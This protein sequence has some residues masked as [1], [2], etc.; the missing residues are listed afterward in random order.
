MLSS[1]KSTFENEDTAKALSFLH[2]RSTLD[3]DDD[4]VVDVEN[5]DYCFSID[6]SFLDFYMV[7]GDRP[8]L[9]VLIPA[10]PSANFVFNLTLRM[11]IR[12]FHAKYGSLGFNP[13]GS[14]LF[15]GTIGSQNLWIAM[16]PLE[17]FDGI[18]ESFDMSDGHGDTRLTAHRYRILVSFWGTILA[19][20]PGRNF[21]M[22]PYE[23]QLDRG[24]PDFINYTNV[25]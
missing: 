18:G 1:L 6:N 23:A 22:F 24:T 3:I 11:P 8:G 20:L 13:S 5:P 14:M 9:D 4:F 25:M 7:I 19:Q 16:A 2:R 21:F 17:Y 12:Q 15:I 10:A